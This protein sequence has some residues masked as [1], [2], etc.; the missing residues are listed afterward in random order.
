MKN[1]YPA[2]FCTALLAV[3]WSAPSWAD[4]VDALFSDEPVSTSAKVEAPS[5]LSSEADTNFTVSGSEDAA[6]SEA[7]HWRATIGHSLR[8]NDEGKRNEAHHNETVRHDADRHDV[9]HS[10]ST[11]AESKAAPAADISAVP[12]PSAVALAVLALIYFLVFGRRR[13]PV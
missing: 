8:D 7:T 3:C 6:D 5:N 2:L 12:E 1:V 10:A 13:S 11:A 9:D 4:E